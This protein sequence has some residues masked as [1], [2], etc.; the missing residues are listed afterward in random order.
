[1]ILRG[2]RESSPVN[3]WVYTKSP[4]SRPKPTKRPITSDERHGFVWPPHWR[5]KNKH[6]KALRKISVPA[7]ST[8]RNL[9][10]GGSDLISPA[11]FGNFGFTNNITMAKATLPIGKLLCRS[12]YFECNVHS[13]C[14]T[15]IQKH[16]R[17]DTLSANVP[18][19]IGAVHALTPC[20]LR[21]YA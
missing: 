19:K 3:F 16:Q 7:Q 14:S 1:M 5:A 20:T 6:T 11:C 10:K 12:V 15:Y 21:T 18:P 13:Q 4:N 9:C 17:H 2:M 8:R